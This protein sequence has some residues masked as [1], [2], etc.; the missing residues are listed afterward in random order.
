VEEAFKTS[1]VD[2]AAFHQAMNILS[3]PALIIRIGERYVH[4]RHK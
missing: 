4:T 1:R 3:D 2:V